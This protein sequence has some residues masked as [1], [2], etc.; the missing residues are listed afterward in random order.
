MSIVASI[1]QDVGVMV[2]PLDFQGSLSPCYGLT[3]PC[4]VPRWDRP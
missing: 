3:T 2:S 4:P 1:L